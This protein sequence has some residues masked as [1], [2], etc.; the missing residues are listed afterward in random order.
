[1]LIL[2]GSGVIVYAAIRALI[3][4]AAARVAR[5]RH[6]RRRLR[7]RRRTWSSRRWLYRRARETTSSPALEGDAAHLRT[8]AYTSLGVLVGLAL[9]ADHRRARGSTRWSRS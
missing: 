9:V 6:R 8:D 1:M 2:V 7:R 4:R 3:A 5:L